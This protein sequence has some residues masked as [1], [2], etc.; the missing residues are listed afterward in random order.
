[1]A[2]QGGYRKPSRPAPV[3]GPGAL[4]RR[5]DGGAGQPKQRLANAAYGEQKDFQQIQGGAKMQ[6]EPQAQAAAAPSPLSRITPLNA[7]TA[8]PDE[9]VTAG[10]PSGPGPGLEALGLSNTTKGQS[11]LDAKTIAQYLPNLEAVA[12]QPG[13]PPS[14]VKFVRYLRTQQ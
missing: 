1:M 10:V 3:S 9:P 13:T 11:T 8:R 7:P 6:Q 2:A 12:R 4:S 14:F 5:T